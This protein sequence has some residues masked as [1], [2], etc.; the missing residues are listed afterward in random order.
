MALA[1]QALAAHAQALLDD[2]AGRGKRAIERVEADLVALARLLRTQ[3]RLRKALSDPGLPPQPKRALLEDLGEG[4]LDRSSVELLA[5]IAARQRVPPRAFPGVVAEL[6]A[7]A[8]FTAA[9]RAGEL[10]Q[11]EAELFELATLVN[12]QPGLRSALT[13]PALPLE[14]KRALVADLLGGR[15]SKRTAALADLLVELQEGRD[16]DTSAREL[17]E[18]AAR[19]RNRVVAEVRSAVELNQQRRTRLAEVLG[20][21]T[22]RQVDLRVTVDQAILGSVVVRIGDEV[23][24]GSIRS[25]LQQAREQLGVA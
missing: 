16:L 7:M 9:D 18:L 25:R 13:D 6:A 12:R 2:A 1:S 10:E 19:R 20:R 3:V 4:R 5:T 14:N 24:D 23:F 8:A 22:G 15:A 17:A 21:I 11:V